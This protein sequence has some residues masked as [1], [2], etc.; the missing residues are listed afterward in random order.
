MKP[1][2]VTF[3]FSDLIAIWGGVTGT[4][5]LVISYFA[6]RRD[7]AA[8]SIEILKNMQVAGPI[9][10]PYKKGRDYISFKVANKGRR[11]FTIE[12]AGYVFLK[13]NGGAILNDSMRQGA[14]ELTEGKFTTYLIEQ[15][16]V[17]FSD[18]NYFAVYDVVGNTYKKYVARFYERFFYWLMHTL[19]IRRKEPVVKKK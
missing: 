6:F 2:T 17:D 7:R 10:H 11:P 19:H 9:T 16:S 8:V 1:L 12:K 18:I 3:I 14:V 4:L 15:K 5:G 13:K